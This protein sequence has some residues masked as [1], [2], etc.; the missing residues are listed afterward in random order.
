MTTAAL[1]SGVAYQSK[2]PSSLFPGIRTRAPHPV[3]T[4][5]VAGPVI[6]HPLPRK[7]ALEIADDTAEL[8]LLRQF[9][10][11][12]YWVLKA[13]QSFLNWK[14]G[15]CYPSRETIAAAVRYMF[16]SISLST[17]DRSLGDLRE[18]GAVNRVRRCETDPETGQRRQ[19]TNAYAFLPSSQWRPDWRSQLR[20]WRYPKPPAP[21]PEAT[22]AHPPLPCVVL[23]AK[24][25]RE[26]GE[27]LATVAAILGTDP[28]DRL[29][30]LQLAVRQAAAR[31]ILPRDN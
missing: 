16:G 13:L 2:F 30:Q 20:R 22:G 7:T 18:I 14:S 31:R 8:A 10:V 15:A 3:W 11:T 24:A 21:D 1:S 17:V 29:A 6:F 9:P 27:A 4:G 5:S 23:E 28:T 19:L 26:R 25:A 12:R